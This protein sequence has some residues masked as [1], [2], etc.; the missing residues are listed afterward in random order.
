MPNLDSRVTTQKRALPL[1]H[2]APSLRNPELRQSK[3][4]AKLIIV[5][6]TWH[7]QN[8]GAGIFYY[9]SQMKR[10]APGSHGNG[11]W[12]R[13]DISRSCHVDLQL[14]DSSQSE[15]SSESR[16]SPTWPIL[17]PPSH[18]TDQIS[19]SPSHL[20]LRH[21]RLLGIPLLHF[22]TRKGEKHRTVAHAT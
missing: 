6:A 1:Y 10:A 21:P 20:P 11:Q 4:W 15:R 8:K 5:L 9:S 7:K 13:T 18:R 12:H 14:K 17:D 16:G 3:F 22:E 2:F 19:L